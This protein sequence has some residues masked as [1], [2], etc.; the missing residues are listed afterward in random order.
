MAKKSQPESAD[1]GEAPSQDGLLDFISGTFV[2]DT[3]EEREAVQPFARR[4]VEDFGYPKA[5]IATHPQCRIR[6]SPSDEARSYPI[7]IAVFTDRRQRLDDLFMI[8]E[9]KQSRRSEGVSQLKTY[10]DLCPAILGVWFNG[11]EHVYLQKSVSAKGVNEYREIP[12]LPLFGQR[13]EDIG[14]FHRRDLRV[15]LNLRTVFK[16]IRNYIAGNTPGITR[17]ETIATEIIN[18]LFCKISDELNTAPAEILKFRHGVRESHEAVAARVRDLFN[19]V[20]TEYSDVFAASDQ[21]NLDAKTLAYVVGELQP[22]AITEAQRDIIGEAFE[23]FIGPTLKGSQ[24]Q[25]FTPRNLVRT[26]IHI[27][28]PGPDEKV[29]DPACGSGGFLIVALE[30]IWAKLQADAQERGLAKAWLTKRENAVAEKNF[31]GIEKDFFLTK[32]TKAYMAIIGDGRGGIFCDNALL[33]AA[34]WTSRAA[35]EVVDGTVDV[36]LT[37]P[38]FG[39]KITVSDPQ[40]LRQFDLGHQWKRASDGSWRKTAKLLKKQPPQILFIERCWRFLKPGGR[41]AIILPDGILG[42]AKVGFVA[43]FIKQH[44]DLLA[45]IDCPLETFSPNTTTKVHLL[46]LAK[47]DKK[48][49]SKVFMSVPEI[50]GHDRRVTLSMSMETRPAFA[51]IWKSLSRVGV[52]L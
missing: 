6:R 1:N 41:L 22:Y 29:L 7:D 8:V 19:H 34:E 37:N 14:L 43:H 10:M 26:A 52:I 20:K 16:L 46:V 40:L 13:L 23:V 49:V 27:V 15:T 33:S 51:M 50:I 35:A 48:H 45:S 31:R 25:F 24:G 5:L 30:H 18:V 39:A 32:I 3:P 42:G 2:A 4:L 9:C 12:A 21:I 17:D 11:D 38:P 44:F 47:K 28:D 36:I